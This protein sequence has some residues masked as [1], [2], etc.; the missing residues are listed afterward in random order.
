MSCICDLAFFASDLPASREI[1]TNGISA[2]FGPAIRW[3]QLPGKRCSQVA[4]LHKAIFELVA[5]LLAVVT[6]AAS[7][8]FACAAAQVDQMA[9]SRM[10]RTSSARDRGNV[11]ISFP[12]GSRKYTA[13][14]VAPDLWQAARDL[15]N[16]ISSD[17]R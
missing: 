2:P 11:K 3:I 8:L 12:C 13:Q 7:Y 16:L 14:A 6:F 4:S 17:H 5:A 10:N 1:R 9:A 15:R